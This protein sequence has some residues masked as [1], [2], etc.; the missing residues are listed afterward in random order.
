MSEGV[1]E[2][3]REKDGMRRMK[4]LNDRMRRFGAFS[5]TVGCR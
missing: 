4:G 5:F 3:D 1:T 2:K